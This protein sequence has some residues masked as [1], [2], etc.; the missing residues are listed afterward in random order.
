[1]PSHTIFL[2]AEAVRTWTGHSAP[3]SPAPARHDPLAGVH[4]VKPRAVDPAAA[5]K[6]GKS[7]IAQFFAK[8]V[9]GFSGLSKTASGNVALS[10][11][12]L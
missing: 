1:M 10:L 2:A 5:L 8:S 9:R 4:F 12:P 11:K 3:T 6:A 7:F